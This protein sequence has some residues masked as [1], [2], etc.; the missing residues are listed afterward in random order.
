M[1][2]LKA[3][4]MPWVQFPAPQK[5]TRNYQFDIGYFLYLDLVNTV[6]TGHVTQEGHLLAGSHCI[7][8]AQMKVVDPTVFLGG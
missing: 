1:V 3:W 2:Q 6:E 7:V 8:S 4:T 5:K